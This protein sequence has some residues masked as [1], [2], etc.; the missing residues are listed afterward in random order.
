[1]T[2]HKEFIGNAK[3]YADK[4]CIIDRS[5]GKN[6]SYSKALIASF[7][8]AKKFNRFEP[9]FLGIMI[10]TSAGCI[11]SILGSLM[12]G[13]TPVM[14]N[15]S[16]GAE[17]NARYAQKKCG[18]KTIVTSKALLEKIDC[19]HIDGMVYI[20][21]IMDR[22]SAV[23]KI[24][25]AVKAKLPSSLLLRRVA[26]KS[27]DEC[28]VMLFTSGSEKDP[29][30]VPLSH[31]NISANIVGLTEM[32]DLSDKDVFLA[33]L[34]LFH[35]FGQTANLW[36]PLCLG[37]TIVSY[38]NPLDFKAI[39]A[40]IREEKPTLVV[41]TPSFFWGYLAKSAPGD[42]RSVRVALA[43]ADKCPDALRAGFLEKHDLTL[44]EAYGA[45][46]TS[47]AISANTPDF[48]RPGS[49]GKVM[50]GMEVAIEDL[51]SGD[52]APV[53]R[54]GKVLV[55]GDS[56]MSG[57]FNDLEESSLRLRHGWYDTGDMGYMDADGYL[58][59]S[60]RLKRFVKIGG[61]MVSLVRVENVLEKLLP[62]G[63]TCCVVEIPDPVKGARIVVAV[64]EG[65]NERQLIKEMAKEL[66]NIAVP[67]H[68]VTIKDLP[69]MGSGKVDFR[70]VTAMVI[71]E[72]S[73]E[74]TR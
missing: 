69:F 41:G 27:E 25:A 51:E 34:P 9:G 13:R 22:L 53:G 20:E 49:V 33:N 29:R 26:G 58:W 5:T 61:E 54:V 30:A 3:K 37:M 45:T 8:L 18:F 71:D 19:P 28:A 11:L 12:S 68:F 35:V 24:K 14:I 46:E 65:V 74:R 17:Q 10:P 39:P 63:V 67:K 42:F 66:P 57:Y 4:P 1:M 50:P 55:K 23:D 72:I 64:T 43:G 15:Y 59:H 32:F 16:T 21:D 44:Y 36:V 56:V 7:I 62:K 73:T 6:P 38:A 31:R 47:P 60:G 40:I 48:N 52:A 2:L 70:T